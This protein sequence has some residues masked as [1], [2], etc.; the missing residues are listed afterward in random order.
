MA[1]HIVEAAGK[2][3]KIFIHLYEAE[4]VP[5]LDT[6]ETDDSVCVLFHVRKRG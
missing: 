4:D 5:S 3:G 6:I 1:Y 2:N